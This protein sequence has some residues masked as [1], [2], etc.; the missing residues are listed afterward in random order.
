MVHLGI[1]SNAKEHRLV[2]R[3]SACR[4]KSTASKAKLPKFISD[5]CWWDFS[6]SIS[7][8]DISIS[9][10]SRVFYF[11]FF[12]PIAFDYCDVVER[13]RT[14]LRYSIASWEPIHTSF[15]MRL[16]DSDD[17][18]PLTAMT[19]ISVKCVVFSGS[20]V[21]IIR[22]SLASQCTAHEGTTLGRSAVCN[23]AI[24]CIAQTNIHTPRQNWPFGV[25]R[26][27]EISR[28]PSYVSSYSYLW[29][30]LLQVI[31]DKTIN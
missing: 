9:C 13:I 20:I 23:K 8:S 16:N 19:F 10:V 11:I 5:K 24:E 12:S 29:D 22:L 3:S 28:H 14:D 4:W 25:Q 7:K 30:F 1:D 31:G 27:V 18:G 26:N 2:S 17:D 21:I 6:C 15:A